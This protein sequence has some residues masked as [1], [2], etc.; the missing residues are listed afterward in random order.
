MN[1]AFEMRNCVSNQNHD[2][3][4]CIEMQEP[5]HGWLSHGDVRCARRGG[6]GI[7]GKNDNFV[8]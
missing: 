3:D 5:F 6:S 2:F 8:F 4:F 1:C 7:G